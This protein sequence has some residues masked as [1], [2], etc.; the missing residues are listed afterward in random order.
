MTRSTTSLVCSVVGWGIVWG[1]GGWC[2]GHHLLHGNSYAGIARDFFLGVPLILLVLT[3]SGGAI[4]GTV[5][6]RETLVKPLGAIVGTLIGGTLG[7]SVAGCSGSSS[8][9]LT[10]SGLIPLFG[11]SNRLSLLEA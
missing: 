6:F 9:R 2:I 1:A 10:G 3:A 4:R 8:P 5:A 11:L 7:H